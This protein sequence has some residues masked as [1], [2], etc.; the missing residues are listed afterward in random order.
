MPRQASRRENPKDFPEF[1]VKRELI[2]AMF[3]PPLPKS[4]FYD[5]VEEGKIIPMAELPGYYLLNASLHRMGLPM[6]KRP[7]VEIS[8][9]SLEDIVRLAFTLIDRDLFPEPSWLLH[10][11]AINL[12]DAD[13]AATLADRYREK[14]VSFD[15]IPL[16]LAYFQGVL[17]WASMQEAEGV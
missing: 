2:C 16:K 7:P 1:P 17:D 11:E 3:T 4:T 5:R 14:V 15:S 12:R 13:H 6:V 8:D 10:A 9:R